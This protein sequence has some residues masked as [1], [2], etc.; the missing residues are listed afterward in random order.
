MATS[1]EINSNNDLIAKLDENFFLE[2]ITRVSRGE[3]LAVICRE[4][5]VDFAAVMSWINGDDDLQSRYARALTIR[6]EHAKDE[7]IS[8]LFGALRADI[9]GVFDENNQLLPLRE[10]PQNVR[11]LI[12]GYDAKE[13]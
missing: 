7:I 3:S 6:D 11:K 1:N 9:T 5:K 12:K 13:L 2:L 4:R 10:M 8:D